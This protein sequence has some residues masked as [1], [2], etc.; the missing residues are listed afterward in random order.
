MPFLS[1]QAD[2]RE[3]VL[4]AGRFLAEGGC[5]AVKLEGGQ[6]SLPAVE[7]I[8]SADIPVM[9]HVGLTP[10]SYRKLGGFKVQG[11]EAA[12]ARKIADDVRALARAGCFAVVLECVPDTLAAEILGDVDPD[13]GIGAALRVTAGARL[14]RC[15][16]LDAESS[17]RF[18]G[19][20]PS[21]N[22][23]GGGGPGLSR[24]RPDRRF[25]SA[26]E[27][28]APLPPPL[29]ACAD[30]RE[31]SKLRLLKPGGGFVEKARELTRSV[32]C[33]GRPRAGRS[34]GFVPT[35]GALTRPP[36]VLQAR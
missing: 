15:P 23:D 18:V 9:G 4:N 30:S 6:R 7:A 21:L 19:A 1:Y 11:R 24:G 32:A 29:A 25:P 31:R 35:M 33:V 26:A 20:T 8:L 36:L 28:F 12:E 2:P 5:G 34:I 14:S 17:P 16:R 22:R 13:A 3:A 27:S 10:Q